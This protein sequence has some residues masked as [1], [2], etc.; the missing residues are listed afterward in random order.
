MQITTEAA[1]KILG[2]SSRTIHRLV[3]AGRLRPAIKLPGIRGAYL[4]D[5]DAVRTLDA[6]KAAA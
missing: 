2:V 4:F 1:A 6:N 3:A 5:E